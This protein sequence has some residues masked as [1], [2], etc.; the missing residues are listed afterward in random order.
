[1]VHYVSSWLRGS[2]IPR[3]CRRARSNTLGARY[4]QSITGRW[5][6]LR[7]NEGTRP[8]VGD[9]V[10]VQASLRIT[11]LWVR[12]RVWVWGEVW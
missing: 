7:V 4:T 5:G 2:S 3:L 8:E 10:V 9:V 6:A 11:Q 12:V 1:M